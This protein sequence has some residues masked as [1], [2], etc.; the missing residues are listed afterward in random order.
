[1]QLEIEKSGQKINQTLEDDL[2]SLYSKDDNNSIP[3]FIKLFLG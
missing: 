3:P 2:I 1:M